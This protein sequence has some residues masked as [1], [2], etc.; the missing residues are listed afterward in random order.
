MMSLQEEILQY[1]QRAR[2]A[3]RLLAQLDA[4]Q[5]NAALLAMADEIMSRAD[6]ILAENEKDLAQARSNGLASAMIDRLKLNGPRLEE[7]AQGVRAVAALPDPVG[8]VIREWNSANALRI[9]KVRVPIGVVGIIYESRPNVTSDAAVLCTK[10]GNATIL[11]GGSEAIHTN[12][13]IAEALQQ[14]GARAGLPDDSV[15]LIPRTDREAVRLMAEMDRY[16]DLI[17]PR[18]GKALIEAVVDAARMPVIKHSDGIC[19]AYVDA[20]AD[21]EMAADIVVNAKTQR[22]GVCNAIETTLI[23]RAVAPEFLRKLGPRLA[24]KNVESRADETAFAEL[25][26]Q[27]YQRLRH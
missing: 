1:G 17:I 8:E 24:E 9:A 14:G 2:V 26:G 19:M 27:N 4:G 11:R 7:M 6:A 23:H 13:A 12:I 22:P 20:E 25:T 21:L 5:K 16:I 15:L 18:G 10:T 3:A